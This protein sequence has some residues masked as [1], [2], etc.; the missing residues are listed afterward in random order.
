MTY[1]Y[2]ILLAFFLVSLTASIILSFVPVQDVCN[3]KEGCYTVYNSSY[4]SILGIKNSYLGTLLFMAGILL[5]YSQIKNPSRLKRNLISI[6]TIIGAG[7]AIFFLIIQFFVLKAY[8]QYCLIIDF[9]VLAAL[10]TII[11]YWK[12]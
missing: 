2:Y 11:I 7:I 6:M 1:K 10:I 9:S 5:I 3:L 12:R 8:C 4:N